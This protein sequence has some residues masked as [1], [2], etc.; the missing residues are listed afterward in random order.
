M[1]ETFRN[2]KQALNTERLAELRAEL[3]V[4][5]NVILRSEPKESRT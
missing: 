2:N 5:K 3:L 4:P 1:R